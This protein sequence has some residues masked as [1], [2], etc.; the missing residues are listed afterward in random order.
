MGSGRSLCQF[1][2]RISL[3]NKG[4]LKYHISDE[5]L[6]IASLFGLENS[7]TAGLQNER[8]AIMDIT[9]HSCKL[10]KVECF[11]FGILITK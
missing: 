9:L 2:V 1:R 10:Y 8:D 5:R 6:V 11:S 3:F 7:N 4:N